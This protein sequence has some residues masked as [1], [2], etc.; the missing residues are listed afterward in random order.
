MTSRAA[1]LAA[2]FLSS[3][4]SPSRPVQRPSDLRHY[5]GTVCSPFTKHVGGTVD[6]VKLREN[7]GG[8]GPS[9]IADVT[10]AGDSI[11]IHCRKAGVA[12]LIY[13]LGSGVSAGENLVCKAHDQG[14][15]G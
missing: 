3:C 6:S 15:G 10:A 12:S 9:D 4:D 1:L 13:Y 7:S 5:E 8:M 14:A 2:I 11:V